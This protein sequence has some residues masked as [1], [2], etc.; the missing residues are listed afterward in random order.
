MRV[1]R[2]LKNQG[3]LCGLELSNVGAARLLCIGIQKEVAICDCDAVNGWGVRDCGGSIGSSNSN[4]WS[5]WSDWSDC[6]G[7]S[8]SKVCEGDW[9][10]AE[11]EASACERRILFVGMPIIFL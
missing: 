5:D 3:S 8:D 4:G 9:I 1:S 11:F 2:S 6:S 10:V 7:C